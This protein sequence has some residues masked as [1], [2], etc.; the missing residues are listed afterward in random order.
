MSA[1]A[2]LPGLGESVVHA[3]RP[4]VDLPLRRPPDVVYVL[5]RSARPASQGP[6]GAAQVAR[7][8]SEVNAES[9][10]MAGKL[11]VVVRAGAF[12][13]LVVVD[14]NPLADIGLPA[15]QGARLPA[16]MK[17]GWFFRDLLQPA[18]KTRF[19]SR[20]TPGRNGKDASHSWSRR[21]HPL[22]PGSRL[23]RPG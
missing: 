19:R 1:L 3:R 5:R 11:A 20:A 18:L 16:I 4:D 10:N 22:G 2:F 23:A 14:G 17:G 9:L 8:V 12:A 7:C 15:G 21:S 13:D 6:D